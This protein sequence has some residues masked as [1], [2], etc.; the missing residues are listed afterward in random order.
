[1]DEVE[2][3]GK[4]RKPNKQDTSNETNKENN[5]ANE[6]EAKQ[7]V[8]VNSTLETMPFGKQNESKTQVQSWDDM[9]IEDANGLKDISNTTPPLLE[10]QG[11]IDIDTAVK[12]IRSVNTKVANETSKEEF[13][14]EGVEFFD[15]EETT[16]SEGRAEKALDVP[17]KEDNKKKGPEVKGSTT[18][19]QWSSLFT[20]LK[21]GR[22]TFSS[23]SPQ[24]TIK[25]K[26]D[27]ALIIDISSLLCSFNE[28]ME[29]LFKTAGFDICAAKQH[30]TRGRRT[31]LEVTF[32]DK[33]T[34]KQY[35]TNGIEILNRTYFGYIPMDTRKSFLSI[36]CRN[37][38]L[39]KKEEISEALLDA[40][41]SVGKVTS[42]KPLI[43]D[44]TPYTTDQWIIV[45][46]TTDDYDLENRIPRFTH[47]WDNK[48]TTEWKSAPKVCYFC[49]EEGHIR[50]DCQ[51]FQE[52]VAARSRLHSQKS[53]ISSV[54]EPDSMQEKEASTSYRPDNMQTETHE[55]T[56][57][58]ESV[59]IVTEE[60]TTGESQTK[61]QPPVNKEAG[62]VTNRESPEST[63]DELSEMY[64]IP[65]KEH[66]EPVKADHPMAD[67]EEEDRSNLL[68]D[69]FTTVTYK[70]PVTK[71]GGISKK[72]DN[73]RP[74]PYIHKG[75]G[76]QS[77]H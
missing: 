67:A 75:T 46:E 13:F 54:K 31:H 39:G 52:S 70:K 74:A 68:G 64:D 57:Q 58:V 4:R 27:N 56:E 59:T 33:D 11:T 76:N 77:Q 65:E 51:Q 26:N 44:G 28:I 48:V 53:N 32:N 3:M 61:M 10:E 45:F 35:A 19:R 6:H 63:R 73:R 22:S 20:K 50:K 18:D 30:F 42:I 66:T 7:T 34:L 43:I 1:M 12:E 24:R 36:R 15:S 38:P 8:H 47:V 29:S 40:F 2:K 62:T 41:E 60:V 21:R 72:K 55:Q 37:V 17:Q 23:F 71:K 14:N 5:N 69:E 16:G 25:S 49:E 9:M